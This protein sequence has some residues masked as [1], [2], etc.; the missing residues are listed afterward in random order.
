MFQENLPCLPR[1]A[2]SERE[3][4]NEGNEQTKKGNREWRQLIHRFADQN[5]TGIKHNGKCQ[6]NIR[7]VDTSPPLR[8]PAYAWII[9]MPS[10]IR[11]T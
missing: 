9:R 8:D 4:K 7:V 6:Q 10:R 5:I 2:E 1:T 11:E 3:Q